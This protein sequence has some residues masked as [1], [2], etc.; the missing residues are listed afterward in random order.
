MQ[1]NLPG[2]AS[3]RDADFSILATR[4]RLARMLLDTHQRAFQQN[5]N[6]AWI[7]QICPNFLIPRNSRWLCVRSRVYV[8]VHCCLVDVECGCWFS[9]SRY[10]PFLLEAPQ[11][12]RNNSGS[13]RAFLR[14]A[15]AVWDPNAQAML[16]FGGRD[17]ALLDTLFLCPDTPKSRLEMEI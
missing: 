15:S 7:F 2:R 3:S 8:S 10:H 9:H 5:K 12:A 11:G 16:G 17:S 6:K 4:N 1:Q 13:W 14:Y